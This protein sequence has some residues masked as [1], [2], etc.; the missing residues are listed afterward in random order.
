MRLRWTPRAAA[1]LES[2]SRYLD[3]HH[4]HYRQT[5]LRRLYERIRSLK[6]SPYIGRPGRIEGTRELLFPRLPYIAVYCIHD[7]TIEVW[8]IDHTSRNRQ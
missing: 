1:D 3:E 5:T 2:I 7:E 8:R 4:P 6:H